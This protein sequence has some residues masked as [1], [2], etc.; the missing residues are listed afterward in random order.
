MPSRGH[1][2]QRRQAR[3]GPTRRGQRATQSAGH[4]EQQRDNNQNAAVVWPL[5]RLFN[6]AGVDSAA[7]DR[8]AGAPGSSAAASRRPP[9]RATRSRPD[10]DHGGAGPARPAQRPRPPPAGTR[11]TTTPTTDQQDVRHQTRSGSPP[12]RRVRKLGARPGSA[13]HHVDQREPNQ[14]P[15][16]NTASCSHKPRA[17]RSTFTRSVSPA[18]R[19]TYVRAERCLE[20]ALLRGVDRQSLRTAA[21]THRGDGRDGTVRNGISAR[22][23]GLSERQTTEHSSVVLSGCRF[24]AWLS[25]VRCGLFASIFVAGRRARIS[26]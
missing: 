9:R 4:H 17:P 26:A 15:A 22:R 11:A 1:R 7:P 18:R 20:P 25:C 19:R 21:V 10:P 23:V 8:A 14:H 5:G 3:I 13:C 2:R 16:P 6:V 12:Q 24:R